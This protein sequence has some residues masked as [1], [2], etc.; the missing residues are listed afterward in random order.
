MWCLLTL[1]TSG[2]S[3]TSTLIH[4]VLSPWR[5]NENEKQSCIGKL[6]K[7][8]RFALQ[9]YPR[10][11]LLFPAP[12]DYTGSHWLSYLFNPKLWLSSQG[13]KN[14]LSSRTK[15]RANRHL[16]KHKS[17][18]NTDLQGK[19]AYITEYPISIKVKVLTGNLPLDEI[20]QRLK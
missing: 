11:T 17:A 15:F 4:T 14:H 3:R 13:W 12:N 6:Q 19:K 2:R 10:M 16:A 20:M 8:Q 5:K 18:C 1:R 7:K 9:N